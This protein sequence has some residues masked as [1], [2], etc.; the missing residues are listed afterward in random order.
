M[1]RPGPV[2]HIFHQIFSFLP[3]FHSQRVR[4]SGMIINQSF[5]IRDPEHA[6]K[7][8]LSR[9]YTADWERYGRRNKDAHKISES[10][11]QTRSSINERTHCGLT[12]SVDDIFP[13]PVCA[14]I[15]PMV[16]FLIMFPVDMVHE[17]VDIRDRLGNS[18]PP[19]RV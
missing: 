1:I 7:L 3:L 11:P 9:L 13:P 18:L 19:P 14:F 12:T 16:C 15:S 6:T 8:E 10:Q 2:I 4:L 5:Q 17:A